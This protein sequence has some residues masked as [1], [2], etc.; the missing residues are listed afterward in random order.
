MKQNRCLEINPHIQLLYD[1][2]TLTHNIYSS[3]SDVGK[4]DRHKQKNKSRQLRVYIK[5]N[6]KGIKDL[7]VRLE[8]I[9]CLQDN[10]GR[11][12]TY[13]SLS[14]IFVDLTPKAKERKEN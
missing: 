8:M 10:I 7:N 1:K 11:K 13:I 9:I 12:L 4:L 14:N 5:I 6:A 3:V 2:G